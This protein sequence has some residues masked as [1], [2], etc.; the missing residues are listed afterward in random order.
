MKTEPLARRYIPG[1]YIPGIYKDLA[2]VIHIPD[3]CLTYDTIRI[4]D[5]VQVVDVGV[6]ALSIIELEVGSAYSAY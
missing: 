3:I 5:G 6:G 4:P 2:Y 1:I